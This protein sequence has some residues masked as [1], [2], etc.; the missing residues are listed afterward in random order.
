VIDEVGREVTGVAMGD[1]FFGFAVSGA[2]A[3]YAILDDY[4]R[5]PATLSWE[6]A[7][8]LPVAAETSVRV[9]YPS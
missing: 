4:A 7:A 1:E 3:E 6:E 9:R 8:A 2:A 5:K